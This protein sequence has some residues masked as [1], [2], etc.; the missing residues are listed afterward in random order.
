M[1]EARRRAQARAR[2]AAGRAAGAGEAAAA[3]PERLPEDVAECHRLILELVAQLRR[4][5]TTIA[6]LQHQLAKMLKDR[7]GPRSDRLAPGQLLLCDLEA[8]LKTEMLAAPP[9]APEGEAKPPAPERKRNGGGRRP[10]PA[11]LERVDMVHE[12]PE[13]E[14]RC[15]PC[16]VDKK[17]IGE[18]VSEQ[19]E[20]R[21]ATLIVIRHRRR[22]YACPVCQEGVVTADKPFQPIEKGIPGPG[23][24]AHVAVS[25]YCDHLPLNR[26]EGIFQRQGVE[27]S[28]QTMCGWMAQA[29]Q[30]LAPLYEREK[31]LILEGKIIQTDDTPVPVLDPEYPK[32]TKTGHVWA[33]N[34]DL[35]HPYL[36]Y[37]YT[38]NRSRDGP[39]KFLN[40]YRGY[41]Q[42]DAYAGYNAIFR[43]RP[44][45]KEVGCWS[46]A[47]RKFT[48]AQS[49][50]PLRASQAVVQI[51]KL[52]AIEKEIKDLSAVKRLEIRQARSLPLLAEIQSW[53][54]R[55]KINVLPKSPVGDAIGY[56]LNNWPALLRYCEDG[57]LEIDNNAV[58]RS[59]R[60]VAVGRK[61]WLFA[62][63]DQGGR[64]AATLIT[65]L[66]SAKRHGLNVYEYL[67]DVLARMP[68]HPAKRLDE[69]LPDRWKAL[70]ETAPAAP[71]PAR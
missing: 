17:L 15:Q 47:R 39:L 38:P 18:D 4:E 29:A 50:D 57:D 34:G 66:Q 53:L 45:V 27:I 14:R 24:L 62:G 13:E 54:E 19:L 59:L 49:A 56:A 69:F 2:E 28:R 41:L 11:Q 16:G 1:G 35:R 9:A 37:E 22:K 25:K 51:R 26:L 7:F 32:R 5:Q 52:Y 30:A 68:G 23:L 46:H 3:L 48:D 70:H 44:V 33:Y 67:R 21:P 31:E 61:N 10:L 42:A 6:G 12:V 65:V 64:T 60:G 71:A 58:E 20:F 40:G 43:E 55:E 36:A 63:S 8:L